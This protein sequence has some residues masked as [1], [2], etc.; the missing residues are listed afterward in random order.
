MDQKIVHLN[1]AS[2]KLLV[3]SFLN[4]YTPLK[5]KTCVCFDIFLGYLFAIAFVGTF[6][7]QVSPGS[8]HFAVNKIDV[9]LSSA[10]SIAF[11]QLFYDAKP[12]NKVA[13]LQVATFLLSILS[14]GIHCGPQ[15]FDTRTL[16]QTW[17]AHPAFS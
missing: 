2:H 14:L 9:K 15:G 1:S 16:K 12:V 7:F 17:K 5:I 8:L 11:I 13:I 3:D 10:N 6:P 4:L